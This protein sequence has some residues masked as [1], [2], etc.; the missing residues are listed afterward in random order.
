MYRLYLLLVVLVVL[1][2]A[3]A[4]LKAECLHDKVQTTDLVQQYLEYEQSPS[5]TRL[6]RS[7]SKF[8]PIR[9]SPFFL[10]FNDV[11]ISSLLKKVVNRAISKISQ[12]LSVVRALN[13][14]LLARSACHTKWSDGPNKHKCSGLERRYD[15]E[16]CLEIV[17]IPDDHLEGFSVW[18]RTGKEPVKTYF[19]SGPGVND[20][21]YL[22]YVSVKESSNCWLK[23][24]HVIAFAGYCQTDQSGRPISGMINFCPN[25]LDVDEDSMYVVAMHELFHAVGFSKSLLKKFET[26]KPAFEDSE[27]PCISSVDSSLATSGRQRLT[28][29]SV[30]RKA[31]QHFGCSTDVDYGV[32]M[33]TKDGQLLSHWD[34]RMMESSIMVPTAGLSHQTVIDPI[35]L[36]VFESSGWYKVNYAASDKFLWGKGAGCKFGLA[37]TCVNDTE[38]FCSGSE[39]GCHF[40]HKDKATCQSGIFLEPCGIFQSK[41]ENRCSISDKTSLKAYGE[42]FSHRSRCFY[43]NLTSDISSAYEM[44]GMCYEYRC[45]GRHKIDIRVRDTKWTSCPAG[46]SITLPGYKGVVVCPKIL[47]V[48]CT[49][50]NRETGTKPPRWTKKFSTEPSTTSHSSPYIFNVIFEDMDYH[51]LLKADQIPNLPQIIIDKIIEIQPLDRRRLVNFLVRRGSIIVTFQLLPPNANMS[52]PDSKYVYTVLHEAVF[53]GNFSIVLPHTGRRHT[54]TYISDTP[55]FDDDEALQPGQSGLSMGEMFATGTV[56]AVAFILIIIAAIC[57]QNRCCSCNS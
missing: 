15:G 25:Q 52:G 39:E 21:D 50:A 20:T 55:M 32:L 40:L 44:K 47:S 18:N 6:R 16:Y 9:I 35:T 13:S 12:L 45:R 56:L 34:Q 48:L 17:K 4:R 37:E 36:A 43:S 46:K 23:D 1:L 14:L 57:F 5:E 27:L 38:F 26:C 28:L 19:T 3:V 53:A 49:K 7:A 33:E 41:A 51:E 29:P 10:D 42:I 31:R 8:M 54:A 22:L 11:V 24:K 30:V 2:L